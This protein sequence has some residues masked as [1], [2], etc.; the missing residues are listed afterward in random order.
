MYMLTKAEKDVQIAPKNLGALE[1]DFQSVIEQATWA[2]YEGQFNSD[3]AVTVLIRNI[4][5]VGYG[6]IVH[7]EGNVYQT[8]RFEQL[9][10]KP[11][12]N[13]LVEG[14][15]VEVTKFGA[16]VRFGPLNGLIHI[17][18]VMD[19]RVDIDAENQRLVGKDTGRTLNVGDRV[20][21]RIVS[22]DLN[23][24]NPQDSK[25]G[26]TMRQPGLGRLEWIEEDHRKG[27]A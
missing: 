27:E 7:G 23:E 3:K 22:L 26:L 8:V 5:P 15:V 18:Q 13:E 6:H 10:F 19:D 16:F 4:E 24:K 21:A 20:K 9:V 14:E 17:S 11:V 25:I 2:N 12:I 1:D